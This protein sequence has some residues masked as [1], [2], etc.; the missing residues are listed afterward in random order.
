MKVAHDDRYVYFYARTAAPI[1]PRTEANWMML[2][3]RSGHWDYIVNR[4]PPAEKTAHLERNTGGWNWTGVAEVSYRVAGDQ[5]Q[6]EIPRAA[7]GLPDGRVS[8]DFKWAD[9]LQ[10]PGDAMDFYVS[11]DTAPDGRLE[12]RYVAQ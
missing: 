5:L 6:I 2:F 7:L 8:L 3:I 9:N 1:T 4:L 11:G 12:F 10:H